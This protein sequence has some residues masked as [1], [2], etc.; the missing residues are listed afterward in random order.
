MAQ[1]PLVV[2]H[3]TLRWLPFR[4][5]V[6]WERLLFEIDRDRFR[7]DPH[8]AT[9]DVIRSIGPAQLEGARRAIT[10][11]L[12][13]LLY[14]VLGSRVHENVLHAAARAAPGCATAMGAWQLKRNLTLRHNETR[15]S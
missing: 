10:Q 12:P 9:T 8:G 4:F 2:G 13:D 11:H 1:V 5:A 3:D 7:A 15:L 6:P 14:H